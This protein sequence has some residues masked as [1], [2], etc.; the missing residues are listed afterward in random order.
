MRA[1]SPLPT[2]SRYTTTAI[3]LHWLTAV[4]IVCAVAIGLYMVEL[5]MSVQRLKLFN[6][7]KWFGI[8]ALIV[9][10]VRMVWRV[11]HQPPVSQPDESGW[12][13]ALAATVH[14][15]MYA[16]MLAVPLVGWAYSSASGFPITWLGVLPLPD[17]VP[18]DRELAEA[19]KPWH[20]ILSYSLIALVS[21]H[22]AAALKHHFLDRDSILQRMR[23]W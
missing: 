14:L 8:G 4:L 15:L 16:L 23:P 12:Q 2:V 18:K 1:P 17:W 7:H 21:L 19:L 10:A 5:P 9:V 22:I 6:W 3:A 20:W 13:H 11:T